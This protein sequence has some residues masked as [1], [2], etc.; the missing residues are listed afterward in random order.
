VV[1]GVR[2]M[3]GPQ[4]PGASRFGRSFSNFW[5]RLECGRDLVDTQSGFRLYP[6]DLVAGGRFLTRRYTF[7]VEVLV[8]AAWADLPILCVPVAVHYPPGKERV[9][10]FRPFRD[11][12][13]LAG[14]HICLV[15]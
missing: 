4:V 6:T 7:E 3:S 2:D 14:L 12:A 1:V 8:R 15:T 13:R 11:S 10:H 9:S 5:V